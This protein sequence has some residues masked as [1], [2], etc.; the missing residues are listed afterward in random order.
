MEYRTKEILKLYLSPGSI[1][2][3]YRFGREE[4]A[5]ALVES[6][7]NDLLSQFEEWSGTWQTPLSEERT[8]T[9]SP[10]GEAIGVASRPD[11]LIK[12]LYYKIGGG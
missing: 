6:S 4:T 12:L 2:R 8:G 3:G 11:C 5:E 9:I 10:I 1:V 7:K